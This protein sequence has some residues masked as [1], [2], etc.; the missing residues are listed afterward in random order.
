MVEFLPAVRIRPGQLHE[1]SRFSWEILNDYL[2]SLLWGQIPTF[3][4]FPKHVYLV[5][6]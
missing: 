5:V 4:L 2:A 3:W 6:Q 1:E